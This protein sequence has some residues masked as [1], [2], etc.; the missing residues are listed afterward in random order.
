[1]TTFDPEKVGPRGG[2]APYLSVVGGADAIDFYVRAFGAEEVMRNMA[3][4][5]KRV[6]HAHLKI[7]GGSILL[8]DHFAEHMGPFTPPAGVALHLQ[9][10]D[11]D[12]L[13]SRAMAAGAMVDMPLADQFWGDR[14][15]V[16]KDPFGHRWSIGSSP[17]K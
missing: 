5:G 3:D 15:G 17:K 14:Y 4:D 8:S 6:M 13:W 12:A 2:V 9:V 11:A 10:E 7:N 1:M 16:L